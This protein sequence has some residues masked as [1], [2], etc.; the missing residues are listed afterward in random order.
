MI[1]YYHVNQFLAL[2]FIFSLAC[3]GLRSKLID[4]LMLLLPQARRE[5]RRMTDVLEIELSTAPVNAKRAARGRVS[6][7]KPKEI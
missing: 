1:I 7:V 6:D 2:Y 5:L 4:F 3:K